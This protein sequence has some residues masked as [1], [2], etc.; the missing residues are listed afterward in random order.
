MIQ[1]G[2]IKAVVI[3]IAACACV[4]GIGGLLFLASGMYNIAA[5]QPHFALAQWVLETGKTRSVVFR[6]GGEEAPNLRDQSLVKKGLRLYRSN[7]QPCHGAPGVAEEQIGHGINPKPPPLAVAV[8]NWTDSELFWITS[9]GLKMSGMP[10]FA[11]RLS[12]GDRWGIV[13]MLHDFDY[14]QNPTEETHLHVGGRILRERG[15][16]E[17]IVEAI[18]SH[19][20]YMHIARDTPLKKAIYACDELVGFIGAC[21]K[22]RP[23]KKIADVPAESVVKKLKDKAFAAKV[24]RDEVRAGAELLGVPLADHVQ[25]IIDA[26]TPHADALGL[27][28]SAPRG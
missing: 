20:D 15:Y 19:A 3:T 27:G 17:E 1:K 28:G 5:D 18:C 2:I 25:L 24:D 14:E 8:N 26:L 22:V 23:S 13:G 6:G 16:P 4:E 21:A 9:H 12:D 7:C 11:P 10:A